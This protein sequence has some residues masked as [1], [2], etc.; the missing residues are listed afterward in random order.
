MT[1]LRPVL[2]VIGILLTTLALAMVF[3]ALA[4]RAMGHPDWPVFLISA[5]VS[6][7]VGTSLILVTRGPPATLSVRQAFLL[8]TLSWII[9]PAAAALPFSF[10]ELGLSYTDAFFEAVSGITTTGST[11]IVG[12]DTAPPGILLWRALLQWLGG[13]G[14]IVM[15]IA[16]LPMLRIGGMQ[17]FR[18]EKTAGEAE[19]V[20]P[21]AAQMA[22]AIGMI[23]LALS[24]LNAFFYWAAGMSPFEAICHAMTTISTG[25][26][27]TS[28]ASIGYFQS[29]AI[30]AVATIFMIAGALPFLLY[31][32]AVQGK[33]GLLLRDNQVQWFFAIGLSAILA[34]AG[35]QWLANG[36]P[37]GDA[38]RLSAFNTVSVLTGT[39]YASDDFGLWGTFPVVA[40]LF[41]MVAGGCTGSTA[42]GIKMFRF[43]VL[44]ATARAQ[45]LQLLQPHG[46]FTVHYNARPIPEGVSGAVMGFFFLYILSLA[47]FAVALSLFG[48]D[49]LTSLSGA[50]ATLSNVG[51]G[52]GD[53]IGPSGSYAPLPDGAKW[54]LSFAMLLG[55]LELF[56]ILVLFVPSFWHR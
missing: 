29:P 30:E 54:V 56:T 47:V 16:V 1:D 51:P 4:D 40:L 38:I 28:D 44:Y 46:V 27:S 12:L 2:L 20:L 53:V 49:Y 8:T 32:Q 34:V 17:I 39:G 41:L 19:K 52:L 55:R 31:L 22:G 33:V 10:S 25:G 3:P 45:L 43:H 21:R 37:I 6:L 42:G 26:Y 48:L 50:A 24:A 9:I 14:I 36:V 13:I 23:Y 35:W 11:V 18:T 5:L 15:A 7:F